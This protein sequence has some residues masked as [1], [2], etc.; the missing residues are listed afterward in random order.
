MEIAFGVMRRISP[1]QSSSPLQTET[2]EPEGVPEEEETEEAA[3]DE[4]SGGGARVGEEQVAGVFREEREKVRSDPEEYLCL[5][6]HGQWTRRGGH[7][8]CSGKAHDRIHLR[9]EVEEGDVGG[10]N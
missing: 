3:A 9:R 2:P 1:S 8:R 5:P 4:E 6:G 10:W 7:V